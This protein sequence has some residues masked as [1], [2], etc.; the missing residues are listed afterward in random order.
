MHT[1]LFS[2]YRSKAIFCACL[3]Q[4]E[5]EDGEALEIIPLRV[6]GRLSRL[7]GCGCHLAA[8][9]ARKSHARRVHDLSTH[10]HVHR[11]SRL[12]R[13]QRL[14]SHLSALSSLR[15]DTERR[16]LAGPLLSHRAPHSALL[17]RPLL[18]RLH[19]LLGLCVSS[20][21]SERAHLW[22]LLLR[23]TDQLSSPVDR[24][25]Q[26]QRV[27]F[28]SSVDDAGRVAFLS[29]VSGAAAS[30][31]THSASTM[32]SDV[33]GHHVDGHLYAEVGVLLPWNVQLSVLPYVLLWVLR[34]RYAGHFV[35][36]VRGRF[37]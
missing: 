29:G 8:L 37:A 24:V 17:H 1:T 18:S 9:A 20:Q 13:A 12:L 2:Y 21:R 31:R 11:R 10:G 32:D 15:D 22:R 35:L 14:P 19:A 26:A 3:S 27:R 36:S 6:P 34:G 25:C 5:S 28:H 23:R 16:Q 4:W 30:L 33:D 7:S